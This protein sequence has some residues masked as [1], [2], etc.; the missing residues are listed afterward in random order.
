MSSLGL[1]TSPPVWTSYPENSIHFVNEGKATSSDIGVLSLTHTNMLWMDCSPMANSGPLKAA[2]PST[3]GGCGHLLLVQH[4][5]QL[6][7]LNC[8][9]VGQ[10]VGGGISRRTCGRKPAEPAIR[11]IAGLCRLTGQT[12]GN[13]GCLRPSFSWP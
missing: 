13:A 9:W 6:F 7:F 8:S 1:V 10:G 2:R 3:A 5:L 11:S 4:Q 12:A